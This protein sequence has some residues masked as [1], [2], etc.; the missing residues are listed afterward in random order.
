MTTEELKAT[1]GEEYP[2]AMMVD[3]HRVPLGREK[4]FT[5]I[6]CH[7]DK[8]E[9]HHVS[10]FMDR[11]A[12]ITADELQREW[13]MWTDA[14]RMDFCQS[15]CWLTGQADFPQMLRFIMEHAGSHEWSAIAMS[16]ASELPAEDAFDILLRALRTAEIG[17]TCNI[18]QAIALTRHPEAGPTL[19]AHLDANWKHPGLWDEA[20][21]INWIAFDATTCIA[22]LLEL[23]A[24][25]AEFEQKVRKLSQHV[26]LHNRDSCRSF[27]SKYYSWLMSPSKHEGES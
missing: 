13:P 9:E 19:R 24:T 7:P 3:G 16:V 18:A 11:S 1:Y 14:L 27:L 2:Q 20:E 12:S 6:F 23:G 26:S 21:F 5:R 8:K 22:H 15:C 10:R 17:S 4:R 25:P